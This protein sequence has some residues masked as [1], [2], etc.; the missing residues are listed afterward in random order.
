MKIISLVCFVGLW[1]AASVV[2]RDSRPLQLGAHSPYA[3]GSSSALGPPP[4]PS[5]GT[6]MRSRSKRV[7]SADTCSVPEGEHASTVVESGTLGDLGGQGGYVSGKWHTCHL[8]PVLTPASYPFSKC[9]NSLS[10]AVDFVI[11]LSKPG[12]TSQRTLSLLSQSLAKP[13]FLGRR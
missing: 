12:Q 3:Q 10:V 5:G 11:A 9:L 1:S 6:F 4:S 2:R 8:G 7:A 13:P